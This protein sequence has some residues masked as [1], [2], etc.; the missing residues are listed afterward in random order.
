M[1][2]LNQ[3][4]AA[5][6]PAADLKDAVGGTGNAYAITTL[7]ATLMLIPMIFIR[8]APPTSHC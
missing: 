8:C 4:F 7:W 1:A 3:R 6:K 5:G 2:Q